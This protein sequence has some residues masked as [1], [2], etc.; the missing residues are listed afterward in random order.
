MMIDTQ[1]TLSEAEKLHA[2][3]LL[4]G[5]PNDQHWELRKLVI[6]ANSKLVSEN[7]KVRIILRPMS[8]KPFKYVTGF[9]WW[10]KTREVI[11]YE[12]IHWY[13]FPGKPHMFKS[14][15]W[16]ALT[17]EESKDSFRPYATPAQ[18]KTYLE[19]ITNI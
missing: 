9:L 13:S 8:Q 7:K 6:L 5:F 19:A 15:N 11:L 18:I 17:V 4:N 14:Y 1:I 10:R 3:H 2:T 16:P 12:L